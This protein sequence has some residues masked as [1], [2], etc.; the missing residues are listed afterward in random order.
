MLY[1]ALLIGPI[2]AHLFQNA[3]PEQK[4]AVWK[5]LAILPTGKEEAVAYKFEPGFGRPQGPEAFTV[6]P[7]G[8]IYVLDSVNQRIYIVKEQKDIL[9]IEISGVLYPRDILWA[10]GSLYVLDDSNRILNYSVEGFLLGEYRLPTG[11]DAHQVYKLATSD[12]RVKIW[13]QNYHEF[14]LGFLPSSV[15]LEKQIGPGI[16]APDGKRWIAMYS[17]WTQ[18]ILMTTDGSAEITIEANGLFGSARLVG[19]DKEG[20]IY[21]LVEDLYDEAPDK[22]G[23]EMTIRKYAPN[24]KLLGVA[25][26]PSEEF[27]MPPTRPVEVTEDGKVYAMVPGIEAVS[28]YA[29]ELGTSYR[30][31][32]YRLP[33]DGPM[34]NEEQAT[35]APA[36]ITTSLNR[37]QVFDR[38]RIMTN[39]SWVWRNDYDWFNAEWFSD[40]RDRSR[41]KVG[42]A[43]K[44]SQ[45]VGVADGATVTGIPYYW[46]GFDSPWT[47]SDWAGSRWSNW[48]EALNYYRNQSK[49]GPL[50]GDV[51]SSCTSGLTNCQANGVYRGGAGI[52]CSGFVAAA[53]GNSYSS[54][55]GTGT[56]AS[57]GYDWRGSD[58]I[59]VALRRLQPMNFLVRTDTS[60]HTLYYF[61]RQ[62]ILVGL[63]TLEATTAGSPQGAKF[64]SR[65]WS[66]LQNY[67]YHRS[68]WI[69]NNGD[70]PE[71]AFT[72]SGS[73]SACYG[74]AGQVVWYKFTISGPRTVTLTGISGGDPD[75]YVYN[76]NFSLVGRSSNSG[77]S[78]ESVSINTAGTYYAMVH[79]WN[80]Q[81]GCVRWTIGW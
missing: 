3:L 19:F 48:N 65:T 41:T 56:L 40:W 59:T 51:D 44:P 76:S 26:L 37:Y 1:L 13:A 11:I 67:P 54:K 68:W 74:L 9:T 34:T 33:L 78:N 23:V 17:G 14:D 79:V 58:T 71:V 77:T 15:D 29:V 18:G 31:K 49:K 30:T 42:N 43:T 55:P 57:S 10:S 28:I 4:E 73:G 69:K 60:A 20:N 35:Q 24:G 2:A 21:V 72:S 5:L 63:S 46:G 27:V 64:F 25:R 75:L 52:D 53:S 66:D 8:T 80:T 16:L 39:T 12:S 45:L 38:A 36:A 47:K 22:L 61:R 62:V 81:G 32:A 7:D 6:S 70:G 50:V